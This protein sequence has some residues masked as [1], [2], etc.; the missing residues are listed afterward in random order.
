[1]VSPGKI[2]L[3]EGETN[4]T[5]IRV[6]S[7]LPILC[8]TGKSDCEFEIQLQTIETSGNE[9]LIRVAACSNNVCKIQG[10]RSLMR[11]NKKQFDTSLAAAW[12]IIPTLDSANLLQT[13]SLQISI[14]VSSIS[15]VNGIFWKNASIPNIQVKLNV[16]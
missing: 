4:D 9:D 10:C 1:M 12:A 15:N 11:K 7:T 2:V 14:K 5:L 16:T 13:K 6:Y 8:T 3:T